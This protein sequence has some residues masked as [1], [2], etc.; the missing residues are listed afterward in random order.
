[1]GFERGE[2]RYISWWMRAEEFESDEG[3]GELVDAKV[4]EGNGVGGLRESVRVC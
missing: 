1:M 3:S 4:A 2:R